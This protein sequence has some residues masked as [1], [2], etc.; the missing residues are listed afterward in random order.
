MAFKIGPSKI[1]GQGVVSTKNLECGE[2]VGEAIVLEWLWGVVPVPVITKDLGVWIN[3]SYTPTT[4]LKWM[5]KDGCPKA[6]H[7]V[8][9]R[10]LSRG[11]ELTLDYAHT[12]WY[13]EGALPH[14]V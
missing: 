9:A 7:L 6:W 2:S 11:D 1:H 12:P 4:D 13:I 8:A 5:S 14:Y 10:D 3:H